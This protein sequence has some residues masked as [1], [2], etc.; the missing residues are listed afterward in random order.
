MQ[1]NRREFGR[2]SSLGLASWLLSGWM[3]CNKASDLIQSLRQILGAVEAALAALSLFQGLLP[4]VVTTVAGYLRGVT[5]FVNKVAN[6]LEDET[7]SALDKARQILSWA[8]PLVVPTIPDERVAKL[9]R[10]VAAAV[11]KFLSFFGTDQAHAAQ[12]ARSMPK[13]PDLAF[14]DKDRQLLKTI[15]P[16]AITDQHSVENWQKTAMATPH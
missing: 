12:M 5:D 3:A 11:D 6:L 7:Q 2:L 15:P 1:V 16:Q 8:T 14:S 10:A 9:I 4:D 13:V